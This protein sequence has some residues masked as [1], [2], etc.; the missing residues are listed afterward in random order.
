VYVDPEMRRDQ[1][2]DVATV[3]IG[4]VGPQ[5]RLLAGE[6]HFETVAGAAERIA[7]DE[8]AAA[9]LAGREQHRQH[10]LQARDQL[11]ADRLA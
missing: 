2:E 8:L 11:D 7:D 5:P 10:R 9:H 4:A 3:A 1:V 6:H